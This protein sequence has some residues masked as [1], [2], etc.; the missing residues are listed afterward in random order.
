MDYR[1]DGELSEVIMR[2]LASAVRTD[3]ALT[4]TQTTLLAALGKYLI[5]SETPPAELEPISPQD[6]ADALAE[7]SLRRRVVHGMVALEIVQQPLPPEVSA[8]VAEYARALH[9][10]ESMLTVA[11][12]YS[13]GA[14][15][16]A[17][18]DYFRNSYVMGYYTEHGD[19]GS[20]HR[21]VGAGG[22]GTDNTD[23][24]LA[25]RWQA[26]EQCP[27]GSHGRTV[28]DFYEA[29]GFTVP[30]LPG[31]VD[32][33]LAQHDWVH[34]LADYGTSALGEV[35]VFSFIASAIPDP[36]GFSYLVVILGLFQTGYVPDV[37]GVATADPG[38]LDTPG[39]PTR[40]G[41]ALQ[42]GLQMNLDVMG[43]V[44]WFATADQPLAAV[45]EKY[46]VP[47]KGEDAVKAGSLSALDPK[48]VFNHE[49]KN[50]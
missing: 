7:E 20:L 16:M 2:G 3:G 13:K 22:G 46:H 27:S 32:A 23:P 8:R 24:A 15:D 39:G 44:D 30:G 25:A 4:D 33:L 47:P 36:K 26:L 48:A 49:D 28:W 21:T 41:D 12:D 50:V 40:F 35:E 19:D 37:P 43:A 1:S 42:R 5:G 45:R 10:D 9:V 38:H 6:L 34:C 18:Q 31:A 11:E 17:R 29:R 14:M